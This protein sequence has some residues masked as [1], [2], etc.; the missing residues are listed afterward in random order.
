MLHDKISLQKEYGIAG[1]ELECILCEKPIDGDGSWKR[2]AVVVVP[3][4][5]YWMVSRREAEPVAFEFLA[6]GFQTFILTYTCAPDGA[7]Y[8]DQLIQLGAAVDFV[9]K[10][11]EEYHV[12]ADEV[13]VVGFSAG[14]HLTGDLA[15]EYASVGEKAG[16]P[17]DCRP[18]AVGL[19]YPVI[20]TKGGHVD[21]YHNLLEG[22]TDEAQEELLKTLNLDEAV[23]EDTPPAFIWSTS[24]DACVPPV[25]A[26]RYATALAGKK[27]QFELHVY[28]QG[29]HG[30][31]TC[32][33]EIN[34]GKAA[35][36]AGKNA[37]WLDD[38][39]S[40]FRLYTTEKR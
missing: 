5:A 7:R 18:T 40:F 14:G 13:F 1:G 19:C 27:I 3:G 37:A 25:N 33:L 23:T 11:A 31:S 9:K 2:P 20:T 4:G 22:Y 26:L 34:D 16:F 36:F 24:E 12:N 6:R 29:W 8:P 30:L 28:P 21:S 39:A 38:C 32:A 10:H 15:V 17:L 35:A